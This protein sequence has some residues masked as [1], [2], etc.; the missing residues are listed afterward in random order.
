MVK[1]LESEFGR[2]DVWVYKLGMEIKAP[3]HEVSLDDWNKV[4]LINVTGVFLGARALLNYFFDHVQ[5]GNII[6]I[7]S[8]HEQI[9]WP[10]LL[11]YTLAKGAVKLSTETMLME[12]ANRGIWVYAI[13]PGLFETPIKLEKLL[14]KAQYDQT[15]AMISQGR[16]GKPEDV[17]AGAAWLA[18]TE[19]S[20]VS[21][22]TLFIDGGMTLYPLF[23][24]GQG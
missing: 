7:C 23:K 20:Y 21:G 9:S 8:V 11:C 1:T 13:G 22:T 4:M 24:D 3:T 17:L 18:S 14:D 6:N 15:V 5:P 10:T 2:L 12:Y 19:C 16:L